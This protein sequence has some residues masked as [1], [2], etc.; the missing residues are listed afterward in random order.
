MQ[1]AVFFNYERLSDTILQF[2]NGVTLKLIVELGNKDKNGNKIPSIEE[3]EYPSNK[4][5]NTSSLISMKRKFKAY[6][7]MEYPAQDGS[8]IGNKFLYIRDYSVMGLLSKMKEFD[9]KIEKGFAYKR[10]KLILLS[11]SLTPVISYP[12]DNSKI[13]FVQDIFYAGPDKDIPKLGVRIGLNDEYYFTIPALTIWKSFLYYID[14]CDL[15]EWGSVLLSSYTTHVMG[16]NINSIGDTNYRPNRNISE[17]P[18]NVSDEY[19]AGISHSKPLNKNESIK[20]FFD[21]EFK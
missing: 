3:Y 19:G 14:K 12:T 6:L 9:S 21:D 4:Y 17:N 11:D 7:S 5:I 16:K 8:T 20:G 1:R 2:G 10:N 13:E 18:D 15:Y